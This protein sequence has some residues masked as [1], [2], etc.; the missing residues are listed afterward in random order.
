MKKTILTIFIFLGVLQ[1]YAQNT[2]FQPVCFLIGN[3]S[4]NGQGFGNDQSKIESSF[5]FVMDSTYIE[6]INDSHF[7]PTEKNP[8]GEHHIDRGFISFD[9]S[10]KLLVFRQFNN[11]GY[12]NQYLLNQELSNDSTLVFETETIENFVPGGKARWTIKKRNEKEIETSFDVSFGN[13]YSCF[14]QNK[15]YKK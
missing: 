5:Q 15:L 10:R 2:S 11:E 13:E 3:W 14:G 6:V 1:T 4:G 12:I 9:K 8:K 7:E